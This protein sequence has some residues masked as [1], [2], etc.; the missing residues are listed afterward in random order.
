MD[1]E[2]D[3]ILDAVATIPVEYTD[4]KGRVQKFTIDVLEES[5][6]PEIFNEVKKFE[7]TQDA[8]GLAQMLSKIVKGWSIKYKKQPFPPTFDNLKRCPFSFLTA[9]VNS[10]AETWQGN[11]Q[12]QPELPNSSAAAERSETAT[13]N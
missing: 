5:L 6:T 2:I 3:E 1:F 12:P 10:I 7:E 9:L 8:L 11:V 4:K 13:V